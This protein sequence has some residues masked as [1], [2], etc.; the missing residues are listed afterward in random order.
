MID[1]PAN[2]PHPS[3]PPGMSRD[4]AGINAAMMRPIIPTHQEASVGATEGVIKIGPFPNTPYGRAEYRANVEA[5]HAQHGLDATV[6]SLEHAYPWTPG[7][8]EPGK[9]GCHTCGAT[10]HSE[11][12]CVGKRLPKNEII[13]RRLHSKVNFERNKKRAFT[14]D[15]LA[16][17][18]SKFPEITD[19]DLQNGFGQIEDDIMKGY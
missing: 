15:G 16:G 6:S 1:L 10:G 14:E 19:A 3:A 18:A 12:W 13:M 9:S 8:V 17:F 5:W 11:D 2:S 4:F 7:T